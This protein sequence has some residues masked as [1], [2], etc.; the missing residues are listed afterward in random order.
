MEADVKPLLGESPIWDTESHYLYFINAA[1]R[2]IFRHT[3][4]GVEMCA[5][6]V[7]SRIGSVALRASGVVA[8]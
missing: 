6:P 3:A 5:W 4:D 2:R 1:G 8:S 7:P